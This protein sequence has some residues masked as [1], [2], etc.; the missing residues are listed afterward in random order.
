MRHFVV[1][2]G[3]YYEKV[4]LEVAPEYLR[5]WVVP[6]HIIHGLTTRAFT[7]LLM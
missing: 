3:F 1:A 6:L 5:D 4:T 2:E 7:C